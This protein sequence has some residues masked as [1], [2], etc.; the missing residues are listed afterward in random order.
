MLDRL[1]RGFQ[2]ATR[3]SADASHELRTPLAVLRG[4]VEELLADPQLNDAQRE[5]VTALQMQTQRLIS[6]TNTLLLLTRVDAGRLQ[7]ELHDHDLRDVVRD[8]LED[9]GILAEQR[10]VQIETELGDGS[11]VRVD[12]GRIRQV[13]LN[14]LDNAVK[15]N[16]PGGRVR[17]ELVNV[18][19]VCRLRVGNTGAGITPTEREGLFGRFFRA[20][21]Q[22]DMPGA[23]LGLSLARELARSHGGEVTLVSSR[24]GW[25]EFELTIPARTTA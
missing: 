13:V 22:E 20:G 2:Q 15:Y 11:P 6:I 17:L 9:A 23:G 19:G 4:S 25:T 21:Q 10:E 3:F 24:D 12:A 16:E 18:D 1:Q 5:A 14:L 7:L 8:C